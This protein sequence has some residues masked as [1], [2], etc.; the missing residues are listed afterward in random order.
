MIDEQ[1]RE[2]MH[3]TADRLDRS[4]VPL[5]DIRVAGRTIIRRRRARRVV[6]GVATTAAAVTA[7]A[8]A[9]TAGA[10][11]SEGP[12][13]VTATESGAPDGPDIPPE[14]GSGVEI[15]YGRAATPSPG[16]RA[17]LADGRV[18]GA[19]YRTGFA[20][21]RSCMADRGH[22]LGG[23]IDTRLRITYTVPDAAVESGDDALCY[24]RHW[25]GLDSAWQS[26]HQDEITA[27]Q[28]LTRVNACLVLAG[29]EVARTPEE[30]PDRL[31]DAGLTQKDCKE[32]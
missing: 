20:A 15:T 12:P 19:E 3:A 11:L 7:F 23:V 22:D 29:A 13:A 4:P 25:V 16:Q 26:A 1:L 2:R 9:G 27:R 6:I 8:V 32:R 21:Y 30:I 28:A 18:T 10:P 14:L 5:H 24:D 17:A 31:R